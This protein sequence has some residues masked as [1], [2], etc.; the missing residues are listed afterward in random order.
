MIPDAVP[1]RRPR[2]VKSLAQELPSAFPSRCRLA[3]EEL[4]EKGTV[5]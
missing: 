3:I 5:T 1:C 2:L 4:S